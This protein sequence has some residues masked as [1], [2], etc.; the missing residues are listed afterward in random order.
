VIGEHRTRLQWLVRMLW[1]TG[2]FTGA[3]SAC[4][5]LTN[6]IRAAAIGI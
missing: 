5:E 1:V 2:R 3:S 6:S 4:A